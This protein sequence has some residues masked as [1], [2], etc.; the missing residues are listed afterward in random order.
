MASCRAALPR[1]S[2]CAAPPDPADAPRRRANKQRGPGTYTNDR[3]P[4]FSVVERASHTVRFFVGT[5]ASRDDCLLVIESTVPSGAAI[6]YTDDW[7]GYRRVPPELDIRHATVCHGRTESGPR[8][9]A[10]DDER[11]GKREVHCNTCAGAGTGLRTYWRGFR[12]VHKQYLK[13][14]VATYEAMTNAKQ[15]NAVLLQRMCRTRA[16]QSNYT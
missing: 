4:I 5:N 2:K 13:H 1:V 6:L 15:I 10:R 7:S 14:F 9:W 3:P 8:E 16:M 11:E 12:G